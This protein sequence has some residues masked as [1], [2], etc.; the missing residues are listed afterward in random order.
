MI[1]RRIVM[2]LSITGFSLSALATP[3]Q[4]TH[5]FTL[6]NG[7]KV[8]VREDHRAPVVV[9]QLWYKV[10][11]SLEA[12][13]STGLSHVL[14]HMMFKGS[15][16][17]G[18]GEASQILSNLG[19]QE[20]AFTAD[21]VTVYYQVLAKDR[22]PVALELEADRMA[23]LKIP[24][25]EFAKELE[26]VK[27]ERRLR[28]D[29]NPNALAYERFRSL[30]Y[31]ASGYHNPPIG[32]KFDLDRMSVEDLRAWYH[33]WYAPNNA[34]LVLVGD[35]TVDE[36]K[37]QANRWFA[38]IPRSTDVNLK[39]P[40][41]L[42]TPGERQ[43]TIHVKAQLPT[44]L[45]GFN[46]PSLSTADNKREVYTLELIAALLDG[47]NSARLT[48]DLELKQELVTGAGIGYSSVRRGD[49]L[50]MFSALPNVQ[51]GKTIEEV[52]KGIWQL[53]DQLK[54]T[55]PSAEELERVRAQLIASLVYSRDSISSQAM[56]IGMLEALDLPWQLADTEL[57]E[58]NAVTPEDIQNV[59]KKYFTRDRL[60]TAYVLPE[61]NK[62]D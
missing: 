54:T 38:K 19:V 55:K 34:V 4:P 28:T 50:F 57:D 47:G 15:S 10:G 33:R 32:W 35:I 41:E 23:T 17:A 3:A 60:T 52:E 2:F 61:E 8:I 16:K 7:L 14:E 20:N 6:D 49:S 1:V 30:A 51:K 22:L 36:A 24:A 37:K 46:V 53:L 5:E 21:D 56:T 43:L 62:N 48:T 9:S 39:K 11:S 25:D 12:P 59:A 45:M 40:F 29:D 42:A 27:E 58:L 26:V 44:L 18:A 31:L 13:G